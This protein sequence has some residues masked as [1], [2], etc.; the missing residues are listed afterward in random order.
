M[1]NFVQENLYAIILFLLL[2]VLMLIAIIGIV[3]VKLLLSA[4]KETNTW[5]VTLAPQPESQLDL[6]SKFKKLSEETVVEKYYCENHPDEP[7]VGSCLICENVFCEKCLIEHEG[8]FFCKEHFRVFANNKWKQITDVRT[9]PHTPEEGLY[10]YHFKR[11]I[12][13]EEKI[14]SFVL[15]HYKI[16]IEEDF[17][18]SFIQ[19][20]VIES[21]AENLLH[22]MNKFKDQA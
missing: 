2:L 14:P 16:N 9:T 21:D 19:L 10:I 17:I 18:E 22:G 12:W 15:T 5:P 7:S 8:M 4:K 6:K 13:K 3:I 20:N 1:N 11:H